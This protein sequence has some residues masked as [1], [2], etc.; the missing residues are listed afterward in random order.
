M[1]SALSA[2]QLRRS[3]SFALHAPQRRGRAGPLLSSSFFNKRFKLFLG[4]IPVARRASSNALRCASRCGASSG[5]VRLS[6]FGLLQWLQLRVRPTPSIR[7][8]SRS[9]QLRRSWPGFSQWRHR[10]GPRFAFSASAS[11]VPMRRGQLRRSCLGILQ[12]PHVRTPRFRAA[13]RSAAVGMGPARPATPGTPVASSDVRACTAARSS[14][15]VRRSCLGLLQCPH[16][17]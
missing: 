10:R 14:G 6:C 17:R 5:Q 15:Q 11:G 9:G 3:W 13:A 1:P 8:P 12:Y 16:S 7:S 4:S 2:G